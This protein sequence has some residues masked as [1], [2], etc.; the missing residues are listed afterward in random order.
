MEIRDIVDILPY[1]R[2]PRKNKA[3]VDR[4]LESLNRHGQVKP[5]V[6]SAVGKPFEQEVVCCGHT[7]LDALK[8]FGAKEARVVIK[9]FA[10]EAQFLDYNIRDNKSAEYAEWDEQMLADLNAEFDLDLDDM[11]F[12]IDLEPEKEGNTDEDDVPD[13]PEEPTSKLGQIWKLGDHRLMCGDS[14]EGK[15]ISNLVN[16]DI[17]E[18]VFTDIPYNISQESNGLRELDYGDWDKGVHDIGEVVFSKG[19]GNTGYYFCGDEQLSGILMAMKKSDISTR[20][21]VWKKTNP[22]VMNGQNLWLPSQELCAYGKRKGATF[23]GKCVHAFWEGAPDGARVHPNQKPVKLIEICLEASSNR[24]D[25]VLDFF[26]GSGSTL[27][28]CEK[29]GRKCR[30]MELDPKYCDVII[31]RWEDYT[32]KKAEL[33]QDAV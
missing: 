21:F 28:A 15:D 31:K 30:M 24:G 5:L 17:I 11:G 7:T 12:E 29:I 32:G 22:N 26:G 18:M 14:T 6:L 20:T 33:I 1:D 25:F 23:N 27:I 8:R 4:V 3:A 9:E 2:N 16:D 10:D 19:Y 13:V